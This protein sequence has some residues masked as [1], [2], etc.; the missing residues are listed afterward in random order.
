M[1]MKRRFRCSEET[2]KQL[3][4]QVLAGYRTEHVA[5]LQGMSPKTMQKWVRQ[6]WDEVEEGMVRKKIEQEAAEQAEKQTDAME[7]KYDQAMKRLGEKDL[8]I[9]IL[10]DLLKKTNPGALK[11]L[12]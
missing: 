11:D 1:S 9:A 10:R 4:G 8:E 6:Y 3:V 7:K 5:R 12:K 2:K